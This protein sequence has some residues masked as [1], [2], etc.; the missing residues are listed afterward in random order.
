V[1]EKGKERVI[2]IA[3]PLDLLFSSPVIWF[4]PYKRL[5]PRG[6]LRTNLWAIPTLKEP[7]MRSALIAFLALAPGGAV[8][9]DGEVILSCT[10]KG[11]TKAIEVCVDGDAFT[12]AYG[13]V[14]G[15]PELA[16]REPLA[17]G[18]LYPWQGFGREIAESIGFANGPFRYDVAYSVDRLDDDHPTS[19]RVTVTR[20]GARIAT[21]A[22]D[23]GSAVPG[24]FAAQDAMATL[25]LCWDGP[26]KRWSSSCP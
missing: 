21:I 5:R 15:A 9:C 18:T 12:Y 25:G 22:C 14:H 20:R 7:C 16:L 19:G 1:I 23:P 24:F 17:S 11:G 2:S 6:L 13:P 10:A 26:T 8:A 4:G 3:E